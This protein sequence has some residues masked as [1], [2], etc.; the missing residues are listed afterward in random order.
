MEAPPKRLK[1]SRQRDL[2]LCILRST[3]C[4]PTADWIYQKARKEMPNISLGTVYR[5]LNLLREEGK[6][7]EIS[8]G[9][10][11]NHYD[12]DLRNH[13]HVRCIECGCIEDVLQLTPEASS[14]RIEQITGYRIHNHRL[15]FMGICPRC[16]ENSKNASI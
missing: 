5:N 16:Q 1:N 2:I 12:A 6:I 13:Y 14:E 7:N 8:F 15:E 9:R 3:H 4:H 10:G 11:G